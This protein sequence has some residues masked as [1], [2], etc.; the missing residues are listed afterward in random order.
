MRNLRNMLYQLRVRLQQI[1]SG[2]H[3]IKTRLLEWLRGRNHLILVFL[4]GFILGNALMKTRGADLVKKFPFLNEESLLYLKDADIEKGDYLKYLLRNRFW[5]VVGMVVMATTYLGIMMAYLMTF[6]FGSMLAVFFKML[7][8]EYG[9][10]GL[11]LGIVSI[12]PQY[13]FYFPAFFLL[14]GWC[15]RFRKKG[16]WEKGRLIV[17]TVLVC[18]G[19]LAEA[20][21]NLGFLQ[22]F[23]TIF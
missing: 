11:L 2:F 15:I 14:M 6:G 19:C 17:I 3:G 4:V 22:E 1:I 21:I 10:K 5:F 12:F 23:L 18:L 7:I 8:E 16:E 13:L 20:Y 9:L